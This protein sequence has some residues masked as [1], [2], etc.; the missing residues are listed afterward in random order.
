MQLGS[1]RHD[2]GVWRLLTQ[3]IQ[4]L[5]QNAGE[6]VDLYNLQTQQQVIQSQL[7]I[8]VG[9]VSQTAVIQAALIDLSPTLF[10]KGR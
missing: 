6:L 10:Q 7:K 8:S 5:P 1:P 9:H 4:R 3:P 2:I